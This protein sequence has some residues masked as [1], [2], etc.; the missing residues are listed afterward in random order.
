LT[1]FNFEFRVTLIL[2]LTQV[3]GLTA[4]QNTT[5]ASDSISKPA[6][7]DRIQDIYQRD[8]QEDS[9]VRV[10]YEDTLGDGAGSWD[11]RPRFRG[12]EAPSQG[13]ASAIEKTNCLN[14]LLEVLAL[15][16]SGERDFSAQGP[17]EKL[18]DQLR[19]FGETPAWG[20]RKHFVDQM[21]SHDPGPWQAVQREDL[22]ESCQGLFKK[23]RARLDIHGFSKRNAYPCSLPAWNPG[24]GTSSGSDRVAFEYISWSNQKQHERCLKDLPEGVYGIFGVSTPHHNGFYGKKSGNQGRTHGAFLIANK[25]AGKRDPWLDM[26]VLHASVRAEKPLSESMGGFSLD[27]RKWFHGYQLLRLPE[28]WTPDR[29]QQKRISRKLESTVVCEK[30]WAASPENPIRTQLELK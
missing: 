8:I 24:S 19:Y 26:R 3:M 16:Y 7:K 20:A 15:A 21:L 17:G 18:L 28:T 29:E 4:T 23:T 11:P 14:W 13:A 22:P 10:I 25:A 1:S 2:L 30:A 12:R 6:L 9:P 27:R 5:A